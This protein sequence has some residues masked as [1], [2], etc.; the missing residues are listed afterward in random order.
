MAERERP[1][2][3]VIV[4]L[5]ADIM[6]L[7]GIEYRH[8]EIELR[9]TITNIHLAIQGIMDLVSESQDGEPT[10]ESECTWCSDGYE[11]KLLDEDGVLVELTGLPGTWCHAY[12]DKWWPCT[13]ERARA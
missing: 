6:I 8:P 4:A 9:P 10:P 2:R 12:E 13:R 1:W 5:E 3:D 7:E 11:R